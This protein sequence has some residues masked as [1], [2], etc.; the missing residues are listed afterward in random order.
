M[1]T[2]KQR[3]RKGWITVEVVVA[4]GVFA[5][6]IVP[7]SGIYLAEAKLAK[8][9]YLRAAAMELVDGELEVLRAGHYRAFTP[10]THRYVVAGVTA[11]QLGGEFTLTVGS[12]AVQ[13]EWRASRRGQ[14]GNV[15][16]EFK[17]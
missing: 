11:A 7:L 12:N 13:L 9:Y 16:R 15:T 10:G 1:V 3:R 14:G 6:A 5:L 17:L 8:A 4:I 2:K